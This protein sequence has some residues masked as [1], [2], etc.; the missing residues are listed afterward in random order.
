MKK[1][2][3]LQYPLDNLEHESDIRRL[4]WHK[5]A[6]HLFILDQDIIANQNLMVTLAVAGYQVQ[7]FADIKALL[8][9]LAVVDKQPEHILLDAIHLTTDFACCAEICQA[10]TQNSSVNTVIFTASSDD[11]QLRLDA[12]RAGTDSILL[13]SASVKSTLEYLAL[14]LEL[15]KSHPYRVLL[16]DDDPINSEVIAGVLRNSGVEVVSIQQPLHLLTEFDKV[17]PDVLILDVNMPD[18]N[19]PELAAIIRA[20]EGNYQLPI[21]YISGETDKTVQLQA[22]MQGGDDYITKPIDSEILISAVKTRAKRVRQ[23]QAQRKQLEQVLYEREREHFALN[24]HAIVSITDRK[25]NIVYVNDKFCEISGYNRE[26]LLGKNHRLLK[27]G[28]HPQSF[29]KEMWQTIDGGKVWKGEICNQAKSGDYYWVE[30]SITPFLDDKGKPYQY[31]AIR[32]D[33]TAV[34][35]QQIALQ[36]LVESALN[37]SDKSFDT[38]V[39]EGLITACNVRFGFIC[40]KAQDEAFE[41][42]A[43]ADKQGKFNHLN[44]QPASRLFSEGVCETCVENATELYPDDEWLHANAIQSVLS[45]PI[46]SSEGKIIGTLGLMHDQA[47]VG[48]LRDVSVKKSILQIF[49]ASVG[50]EKERKLA[51]QQSQSHKERLQRGQLYANLGTWELDAQTQDFHWTERVAALI[52][53]TPQPTEL[54]YQQFLSY[55]HPQDKSIVADTIKNCIQKGRALYLEHRVIW[56]NGT[57]RWL[58]EKGDIKCDANGNP[59]QIVAVVQDIDD[60]KRMELALA[61]RET[62]LHKAQALAHIG[63]WHADIRTGELYWSDEVFNIFGYTPQSF[64]PSVE[65]FRKA[66]HPKDQDKVFASEEQAAKTGHHNVVHRIILPNGNIRHVHELAKAELD[67]K[68]DIAFMSG[69]VQDITALIEVQQKLQLARDEAEKANKA[70]SEFLS[71]MSHELRTPLNAILGFS[72]LLEQDQLNSEQQENVQEVLKAGKHLLK[73]INEVLDLAKVEAG[74]MS[75]SIE[76][77]DL[78]ALICDCVNLVAAQADE[79]Q[80][81]IVTSL[82]PKLYVKADFIRLKQVILNLLSNAIKFNKPAG[83]IHVLLECKNNSVLMSVI[84]TGIGIP[85]AQMSELFKP[86]SRLDAENSGIEGTGIGLTITQKLVELMKGDILVDSVEDL[87]SRFTVQLLLDKNKSDQPHNQAAN[88][89]TKAQAIQIPLPN[90]KDFVVVYIED[91]PANLKLVEQIFKNQMAIKLITSN[92]PENGIEMIYAMQPDLILLDINLPKM[93][94][95]QVNQILQQDSRV[96]QI[97]VV[98]LTANAMTQDI[99]KGKSAGFYRYLTKP[100]DVKE[101][102]ALVNHVKETKQKVSYERLQN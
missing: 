92:T 66:V 17:K 16:V 83:K 55:V 38:R 45:V 90:K 101:L 13:K 98:A 80:I 43:L 35:K 85:E 75:L 77:V 3:L 37:T 59:S 99:E 70:K 23:S 84:D 61:E 54:T 68:G 29:Y 91:N 7:N 9:Q 11:I 32:T 40:A 33:I 30:S 102:L 4:T 76:A 96:S 41:L 51:E 46:V 78:S 87:G 94:G 74:K 22:L 10:S 42:I 19:G 28:Q 26:E 57:V 97:P 25:G 62:Q 73:L 14:H 27:S 36:T 8:A 65:I 2:K 82:L 93:D 63:S 79:R 15:R 47:L 53:L 69:T 56:P 58:L 18:A 34:K 39:V 6:G 20:R 81:K 88:D 60:R 44:A 21:L 12:L 71:V 67:E 50:A 31:V 72:Q 48:V 49:A 89:S 1:D 64:Q 86:F 52:G 24:M 5:K 100:I 95:Y